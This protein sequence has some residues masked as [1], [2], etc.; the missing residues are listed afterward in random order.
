VAGIQRNRLEKHFFRLVI[1]AKEPFC[2]SREIESFK[3]LW[4]FAE[5]RVE[6]GAGRPRVAR[7]DQRIGISQPARPVLGIQP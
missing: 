2:N 5:V 4:V 3:I 1:V 7:H 6:S